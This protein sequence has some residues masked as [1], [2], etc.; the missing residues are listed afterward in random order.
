[1][2]LLYISDTIVS[3]SSQTPGG[4][5]AEH[6]EFMRLCS[7]GGYTHEPPSASTHEHLGPRAQ[8]AHAGRGCAD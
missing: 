3:A 6:V 5:W 7:E 4:P 8:K 2:L 1:M